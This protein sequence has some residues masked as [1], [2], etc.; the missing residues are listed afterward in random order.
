MISM[1]NQHKVIL[2][3]IFEKKKKTNVQIYG[4]KNYDPKIYLDLDLLGNCLI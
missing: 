3:T 4:N 1:L 2:N